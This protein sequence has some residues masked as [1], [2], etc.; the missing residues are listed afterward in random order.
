MQTSRCSPCRTQVTSHSQMFVSDS[1]FHTKSWV[2][3]SLLHQDV[4]FLR[5]TRTGITPP[6]GWCSTGTRYIDGARFCARSEWVLMPLCVSSHRTMWTPPSPSRP[7][8]ARTWTSTGPSTRS[9]LPLV[10]L[11]EP[12]YCS[13]LFT[14]IPVSMFLKW[15]SHRTLNSISFLRNRNMYQSYQVQILCLSFQIW[16]KQK[17]GI[18]I[19]PNVYICVWFSRGT[20]WNR[21]RTT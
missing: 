18:L 15:I 4:S 1:S 17:V 5:T 7:A 8:S 14:K 11:C 12:L 16:Y 6:R 10:L 20:W 21:P 3:L 9:S 19:N 13:S 2:F